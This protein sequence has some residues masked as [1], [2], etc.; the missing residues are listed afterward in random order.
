[1]TKIKLPKFAIL[2]LVVIAV[3]IGA[4]Y[5]IYPYKFFSTTKLK[6]VAGKIIEADVLAKAIQGKDVNICNELVVKDELNKRTHQE[7]H[8]AYWGS[9]WICPEY[10]TNCRLNYAT[11][12][13]DADICESLWG[14]KESN[15]EANQNNAGKTCY[16][17]VA[18]QTKNSSLCFYNRISPDPTVGGDL[19]T[20][21]SDVSLC[22]IDAAKTANDITLC[23]VLKGINDF[24]PNNHALGCYTAY[25]KEKKDLAACAN[26]D[27]IF[28]DYC[29]LGVAESL[30]DSSVCLKLSNTILY[31][32]D[33][34]PQDRCYQS[35]KVK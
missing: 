23:N 16:E 34:G 35:L 29:M 10:V 14:K 11:F 17:V 21:L 7:C 8:S 20:S 6:S 24:S 28:K 30:N 12:Y 15:M 18:R 1:M 4:L 27:G 3:A 9:T 5:V 31:A 19:Q 25:G 13:N 32:N 26:A 22:V 2:I 33:I